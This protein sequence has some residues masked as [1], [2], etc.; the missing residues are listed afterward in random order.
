MKRALFTVFLCGILSTISAQTA[1]FE[2][3]IRAGAGSSW[4]VPQDD[5]EFAFSYN[6]SALF[7]WNIN[8]TMALVANPGYEQKGNLYF[9]YLVNQGGFPIGTFRFND[10]V[11]YLVVP[12]LF[13]AS[14]GDK[15]K[16]FIQAGPS[17]NFLM[18]SYLKSD[19]QDVSIEQTELF[20]SFELAG[21]LGIGAT[22]PLSETLL[23][24]F[25]LR[26]NYGFTNLTETGEYMDSQNLN[27]LL[28]VGLQYQFGELLD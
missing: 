13:R 1:H 8:Q 14:F 5:L 27:V 6:I 25:E 9:N 3:G 18:S 22:I 10:Q 28:M 4:F 23:L 26:G 12:V 21:L 7:K 17:F 15:A 2:T 24:E 19:F 11:N 20:N 16:F